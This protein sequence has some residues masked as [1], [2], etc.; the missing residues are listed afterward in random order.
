MLVEHRPGPASQCPISPEEYPEIRDGIAKIVFE[1]L[2]EINRCI[3]RKQ[4]L[5]AKKQELGAK[6]QELGAKKQELGAKKQVLAAQI[7]KK[8]EIIA[9]ADAT[10][11]NIDQ[12]LDKVAKAKQDMLT[13]LFFGIFNGTPCPAEEVDRLFDT[14][15]RQSQSLVLEKSP[16]GKSIPKLKSMTAITSYLDGHPNVNSCNFKHLQGEVHDIPTFVEYLKK[17]TCN[18]KQITI[19]HNIPK[20][21]KLKLDEAVAAKNGTLRVQYI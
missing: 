3:E 21:S 15:L 12:K 11:A 19:S 13:K 16:A 9:Q 2:P 8:D 1:H 5:A 4:E 17:P 14:H 6:K 7:A 10:L 18:V 20:E